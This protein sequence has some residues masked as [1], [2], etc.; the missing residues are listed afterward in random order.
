MM[1]RNF[2]EFYRFV[3]RSSAFIRKELVEVFRQTPLILTLVLGPFLIM[4]LFGIGYRNQT[5]SLRTLIVMQED[6]PFRQQV[7]SIVTSAGNNL[8]Y[9]GTTSDRE[10]AMQE[11]RQGNVDMVVVIPPNALET[12]QNNQQ[13]V[14]Q[15]YHNEIDPYQVSYVEYFGSAYIDEVNHMI[16]RTYAEQGQENAS[17][18]EQKLGNAQQR[19]RTMRQALEAG[20]AVAAQDEQQQLSGDIDA[21]SLLVGGSLG[22]MSNIEGQK[23][24]GNPTRVSTD[25]EAIKGSISQLQEHHQELGNIQQGQASYQP[26]LEKLDQLDSDLSNLEKQLKDFQSVEPGVLVAPLKSETVGLQDIKLRP[27]DFFAPAVIILLLQHLAVTFSA[28]AIVREERAGSMELLRISP[29]SALETLLGKYLSYVLFGA[30]LAVVITVTVVLA[31]KVPMLGTWVNYAL[32]VLTLLFAALGIGFLLSLIA[33]TEMQAVQYAMFILLGSVF[34][35]GFFL[36]LRYLWEPV[37]AISWMLPATYAIRLT[38]S[39]MLRGGQID[40]R[41]YALLLGIGILLFGVTWLML[42]RRLQSEWS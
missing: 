42:R 17:S 37:R 9:K 24:D 41:L 40:V 4:L 23:I 28:L 13:V 19:V 33:K 34:F 16:L 21:I 11:L 36:D 12:I 18:L 31:L 27:M 5:R 14:V 7:E 35:S 30:M 25:N 8:I 3:V 20:N 15:F 22:L 32:V 10:A 6:D 1:R 38:Q 39:L 26:E 2:Y 29:L